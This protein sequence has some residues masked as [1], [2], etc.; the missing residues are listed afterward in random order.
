MMRDEELKE[1]NIMSEAITG[2]TREHSYHR[3]NN[4][5]FPAYRNCMKNKSERNKNENTLEKTEK[6]KQKMFMKQTIPITGNAEHRAGLKISTVLQNNKKCKKFE[7]LGQDA[8]VFK[9]ERPK[10]H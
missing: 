1:S 2:G 10:N 8:S 6:K 5:N 4:L 3:L 9:A 7:K